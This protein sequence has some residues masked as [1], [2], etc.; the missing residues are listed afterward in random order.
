MFESCKS[1]KPGNKLKKFELAF[2]SL[3][4]DTRLFDEKEIKQSLQMIWRKAQ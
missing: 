2:L 4:E 3:C 1:K